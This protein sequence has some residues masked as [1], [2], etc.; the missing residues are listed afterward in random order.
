MLWGCLMTFKWSQ[1]SEMLLGMVLH[2]LK[3]FHTTADSREMLKFFGRINVIM[4][5]STVTKQINKKAW[6]NELSLK[7]FTWLKQASFLL[8]F[9]TLI[10]YITCVPFFFLLNKVS[11]CH[12]QNICHY[13]YF[14]LAHSFSCLQSSLSEFSR[15]A[16]RLQANFSIALIYV[17]WTY[18]I[19]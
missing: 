1:S 6:M 18:I 14:I 8:L 11:L 17:S 13:I 9:E 4:K 5:P 15:C 7:N 2:V 12:V 19:K 16:V 10:V 3:N